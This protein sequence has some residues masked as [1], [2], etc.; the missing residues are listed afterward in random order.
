MRLGMGAVAAGGTLGMLIPPSNHFILYGVM[1]ET[2]VSKLF[3]AGIVP[4]VLLIIAFVTF[5]VIVFTLRPDLARDA[6]AG[7]KVT[8]ADRWISLRRV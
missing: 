2:S 8:W 3:A 5:N 4:G 6:V 1:T 7:P